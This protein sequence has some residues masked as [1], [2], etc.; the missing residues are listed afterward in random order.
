MTEANKK[1]VAALVTQ[2]VKAA[3]SQGAFA[4][5]S[6][7]SGATVNH[8]L[9]GKWTNIADKMWQKVA[10]F[11]K[12]ADGDWMPARTVNFNAI[13]QGCRIAQ[14]EGLSLALSHDAG[15]GK[16]FAM[17]TYAAN[18]VNAFYLQCAEYWTKK[19]FLS[20]LYRALGK[21]PGEMTSAD[22][23]DNI[24]AE[25]RQKER[26]LVILDE[27]DKLRDPLL[28]FYI[29]LYNKLDGVCGFYMAGAPA[30]ARAWE[31][32]AKRDKRGFK[33]IYSR[34]GRRF[35]ELRR[36]V[37]KDVELICMANGVIEAA[38]VQ[39]I[40]NEVENDPDLRRVERE[41]KK[42]R[43]PLDKAA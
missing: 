29:E 9:K 26:P 30:L 15:A 5:R 25:L 3:G 38:E 41:I 37:R 28:M 4:A 35:L 23:A 33:E 32:N 20:N 39:R 31:S 19:L 7:I 8:I 2:A 10:T 27:V 40:W 34:I 11:V 36:V 42:L 17:Q 14:T 12:H 21:D 16:T 43:Q 6:H 18:N 13:M 22:L 24:I 1:A